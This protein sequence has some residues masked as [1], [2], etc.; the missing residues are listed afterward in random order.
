[1]MSCIEYP[2]TSRCGGINEADTPSLKAMVEKAEEITGKRI[3]RLYIDRGFYDE[4]NFL[5]LDRK[6]LIYTRRNMGEY[7]V[8]LRSLPLR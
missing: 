5:W 6:S 2:F 4:D 1:M 3:K 8:I 7:L